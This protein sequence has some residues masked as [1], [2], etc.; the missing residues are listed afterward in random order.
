MKF[1]VLKF[2]SLCLVV[3]FSQAWAAAEPVSTTFFGNLA[4]GGYDSVAY[5]RLAKGEA[6]LKGDDAFVVEWKGAKWRFLNEKDAKAFAENP[7]K[8]SP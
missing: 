7:E 8:Y 6:A 3:V 1:K 4:A 5:H 2:L